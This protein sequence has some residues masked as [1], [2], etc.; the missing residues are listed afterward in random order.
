RQRDP[1]GARLPEKYGA[2]NQ[3]RAEQPNP[4]SF[5]RVRSE[6]KKRCE[7]NQRKHLFGGIGVPMAGEAGNALG[8][9]VIVEIATGLM[10]FLNFA[11]KLNVAPDRG[12]GAHSRPTKE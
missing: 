2:R 12:N 7:H 4:Q 8:Y 9:V 11:S 10:R 5:S 3:A 1:D 6:E